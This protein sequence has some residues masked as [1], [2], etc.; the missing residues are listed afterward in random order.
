MSTIASTIPHLVVGTDTESD[1][2]DSFFDLELT[3]HDFDNKEN[4]NII[5]N[6]E[7][8]IPEF[9][10]VTKSKGHG[11]NQEG[12]NKMAS[13]I[14]LSHNEPISKRK[15]LPVEPI[16]K[17]QSPIALLKSA[18]SFKIFTF[19]KTKGMVP[20]KT[21]ETVKTHEQNKKE[22]NIFAV[23]L[24]IEEPHCS[25]TLGRDNSMKRHKNGTELRNQASEEKAKS[26]MFSKDVL[27]K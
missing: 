18:P 24:S 10:T 1:E 13:K 19:R 22:D 17:L 3:I 2:E 27:Q 7:N 8:N 5:I 12:V 14:T 26:E 25:H 20:Q 16:P 23:K 11:F 15:V 21:N 6:R 4:S 9:R